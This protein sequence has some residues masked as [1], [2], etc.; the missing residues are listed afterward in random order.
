MVHSAHA[1]STQHKKAP[2]TAILFFALVFA[3]PGFADCTNAYCLFTRGVHQ[4]WDYDRLMDF[5]FLILLEAKAFHFLFAI[6]VFFAN[7]QFY[8]ESLYKNAI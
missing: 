8:Y 1:N 7:R 6:S 4:N 5:S 2:I 3:C